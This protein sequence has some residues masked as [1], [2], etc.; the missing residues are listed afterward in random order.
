V[1]HHHQRP[2]RDAR[3]QAQQMAECRQQA[4]AHIDHRTVHRHHA[5]TDG[6]IDGELLR[7]GIHIDSPGWNTT[8]SGVFTQI[9]ATQPGCCIAT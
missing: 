6:R 1:L 8:T 9:D 7:S 5:S 3:L 2:D 4:A